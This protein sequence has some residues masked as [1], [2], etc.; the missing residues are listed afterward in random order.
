MHVTFFLFVCLFVFCKVLTFL[1]VQRFHVLTCQPAE[2]A[3]GFISRVVVV[4]VFDIVFVIDDV[5]FPFG[6]CFA[7]IP[8][9]HNK[10]DEKIA[11]SFL[12]PNL[13]DE[14]SADDLD[15]SAKAFLSTES[16]HGLFLLFLLLLLLLVCLFVFY[17][18]QSDLFFFFLVKRFPKIKSE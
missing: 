15:V 1:V 5:G 11:G 18:L 4:V 14:N 7:F 17:C 2:A 12:V 10:S 3:L 6:Q 8:G 13:S 9:K 16:F